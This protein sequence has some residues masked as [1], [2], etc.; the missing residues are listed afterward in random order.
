MP[1]LAEPFITSARAQ[2]DYTLHDRRPRPRRRRRPR[3]LRLRL[4]PFVVL[5]LCPSSHPHLM[6]ATIH[7]AHADNIYIRHLILVFAVCCRPHTNNVCIL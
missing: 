3:R 6:R 7:R 4:M 5:V 2:Y 1:I